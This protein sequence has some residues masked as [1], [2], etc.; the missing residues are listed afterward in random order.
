MKL[1]EL[2][3]LA[4]SP[5]QENEKKRRMKIGKRII[6]MVIKAN[7]TIIKHAKLYALADEATGSELGVGSLE[8]ER[9]QILRDTR[10]KMIAMS[11]LNIVKLNSIMIQMKKILGEK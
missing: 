7:P 11:P 5:P 6:D 4:Q 9:N 3:S 10:I 8:L 1:N 2:T